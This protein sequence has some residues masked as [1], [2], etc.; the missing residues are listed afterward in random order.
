[1]SQGGRR[2]IGPWWMFVIALAIAG[3]GLDAL[4]AS[5]LRDAPACETDQEVDL[6]EIKDDEACVESPSIRLRRERTPITWDA[7]SFP[8]S[9]L[10]ASWRAKTH[11]A[12]V[13]THPRRS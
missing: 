5:L 12:E 13:G 6:D 7:S 3:A 8:S 2:F 11:L 9:A 1:M 10:L 4:P